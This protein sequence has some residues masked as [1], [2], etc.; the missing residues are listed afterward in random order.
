MLKIYSN[1]VLFISDKLSNVKL[2]TLYFIL[3]YG[4]WW[5]I[6]PKLNIISL[7]RCV[8]CIFLHTKCAPHRRIYYQH[9]FFIAS[10]NTVLNPRNSISFSTKLNFCKISFLPDVVLFFHSFNRPHKILI[11]IMYKHKRL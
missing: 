6:N 9:F 7:P 4:I 3:V 2:F 5:N 8:T 10:E 11:K 1:D